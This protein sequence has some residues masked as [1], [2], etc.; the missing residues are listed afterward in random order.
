MILAFTYRFIDMES[1]KTNGKSKEDSSSSNESGWTTYIASPLHETEFAIEDHCDRESVERDGYY[2]STSDNEV[3]GNDDSTA[4]DATSGPSHEK[5]I[6]LG[7]KR[8]YVAVFTDDLQHAGT[9]VKRK[10][11]EELYTSKKAEK[12]LRMEKEHD[13]QQKGENVGEKL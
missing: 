6:R 3:G 1:S 4:S 5:I 12:N 11:S 7:I 13:D 9:G 2:K 8:G 10:D